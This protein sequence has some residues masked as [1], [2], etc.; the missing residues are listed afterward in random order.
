[1]Y[2]ALG[3]VPRPPWILARIPQGVQVCV[4]LERR[5][6][7]IPREEQRRRLLGAEI[8]AKTVWGKY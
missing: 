2:L 3:R 6:S 7:M 5:E 4:V 8:L 1:M